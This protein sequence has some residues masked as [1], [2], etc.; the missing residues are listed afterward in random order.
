[1]YD[2]AGAASLLAQTTM[3]RREHHIAYFPAVDNYS[4]GPGSCDVSC[5]T[6]CDDNQ[7]QWASSHSSECYRA[8]I[9]NANIHAPF[10]G[11]VNGNGRRGT[12]GD[13]NAREQGE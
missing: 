5:G 2:G 11:D 10:F 4:V 13:R 3:P 8:P 12:N 1:M 6:A 9:C 7:W